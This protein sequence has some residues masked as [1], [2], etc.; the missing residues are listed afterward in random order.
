MTHYHKNNYNIQKFQYQPYSDYIN[1]FSLN[2]YGLELLYFSNPPD[3]SIYYDF[4]S[5]AFFFYISGI[6]PDELMK[7]YLI[8]KENHLL[9]SQD[10]LHSPFPFWKRNQH[11]CNL[12]GY[13][14]QKT[15]TSL[16]YPPYSIYHKKDNT[17]SEFR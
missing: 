17:D 16:N 13:N 2:T 3:K 7:Y 6:G 10:I 11:I 1:Y 5:H 14:I 4:K 15:E 9:S 12:K 8:E